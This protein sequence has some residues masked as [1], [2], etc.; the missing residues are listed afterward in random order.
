MDGEFGGIGGFGN[1]G[2]IRP[3]LGGPAVDIVVVIM[4]GE[5]FEKFTACRVVVCGGQ[6]C[7]MFIIIGC[8]GW[9]IS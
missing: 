4:V 5:L 1:R 3:V 9:P 8:G 6:C 7:T 2:L